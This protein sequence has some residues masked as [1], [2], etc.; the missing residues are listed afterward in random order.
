MKTTKRLKVAREARG[1]HGQ[2]EAE[3]EVRFRT[4][5]KSVRGRHAGRSK[6]GTQ[7]HPSA[8]KAFGARLTA[9]AKRSGR[10]KPTG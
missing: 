5:A 7:G 4:L 1:D 6:P 2:T 8:P 10:V 9:I 3:R